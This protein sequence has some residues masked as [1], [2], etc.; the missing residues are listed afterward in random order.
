MLTQLGLGLNGDLNDELEDLDGGV[1]GTLDEGAKDDGRGGELEV[2]LKLEMLPFL[3]CGEDLLG[4]R[5]PF[6]RT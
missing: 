3:R 6:G 5:I 4:L 2:P 1:T